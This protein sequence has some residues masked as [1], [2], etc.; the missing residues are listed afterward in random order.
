MQEAVQTKIATS[1][2]KGAP[3]ALTPEAGRLSASARVLAAMDG[4]YCLTLYTLFGS[5]TFACYTLVLIDNVKVA[6]SN[7]NN[8]KKLIWKK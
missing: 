2:S 7:T 3:F 4:T 1:L 5:D 8:G 6:E